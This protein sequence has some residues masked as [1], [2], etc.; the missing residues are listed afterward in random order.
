[1]DYVLWQELMADDIFALEENAVSEDVL[2]DADSNEV[3]DDVGEDGIA[4]GA[5]EAWF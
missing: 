4:D 3:V 2:V 5:E 1:V